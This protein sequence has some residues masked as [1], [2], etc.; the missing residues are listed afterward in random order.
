[1]KYRLHYSPRIS[2][3]DSQSGSPCLYEQLL[4]QRAYCGKGICVADL[5]A[6]SWEQD[7]LFIEN[8]HFIAH[9]LLS[10]LIDNLHVVV[11]ADQG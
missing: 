8:F 4:M 10:S 7:M 2:L 11:H 9:V 5:S 1:M 3:S 6:T